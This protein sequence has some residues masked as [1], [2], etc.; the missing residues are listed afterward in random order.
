MRKQFVHFFIAGLLSFGFSAKLIAQDGIFID[1]QG[2]RVI[3]NVFNSTM[4]AP[5]V[6]DRYGLVRGDDRALI[7]IVVVRP[8][9]AGQTL[10][11]PAEIS[12]TAT[13]LLQQAQT[14]EFQ[15]IEEQDTVYYLASMRHVNEEM[16]HFALTIEREDLALPIELKFSKKLY[17]E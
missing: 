8:L 9:A 10:G 3:Y 6:A 16:Y 17:V 13:N 7:N 12:G 14:L 2:Y 11:L 4:I 1:E 15:T 5:E